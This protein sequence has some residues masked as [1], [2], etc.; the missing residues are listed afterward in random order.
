[1]PPVIALN[2]HIVV[3]GLE[4][5]VT[6]PFSEDRITIGRRTDNQ[7]ILDGDNISRNHVAIERRQ[8]KYFVCDLG[9]ANGTYL[10]EERID[11]SVE[12]TEGD[13]LRIGNYTLAVS[14]HE[15]DC[16]LNFKKPTK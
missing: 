3:K 14:F 11:D 15:Q 1:L 9:S 6:Q 13:R 5:G 7:V 16:V 12:L 8:G 2:P 4:D 10:N